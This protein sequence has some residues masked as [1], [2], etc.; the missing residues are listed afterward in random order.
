[1]IGKVSLRNPKDPKRSVWHVNDDITKLDAMYT[2]LLGRDGDRMLT[3]DTKWLA[4]THKSFDFGR[5]GYNT[6]LGYFGETGLGV[7]VRCF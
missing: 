4:V 5:R 3:T 2:R 7:E 6:R 1:M